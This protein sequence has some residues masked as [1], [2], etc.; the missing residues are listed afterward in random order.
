MSSWTTAER[1]KAAP[2]KPVYMM[3]AGF[4]EGS[5]T[6]WMGHDVLNDITLMATERGAKRAYVMSG[7]GPNEMQLVECYD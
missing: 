4:F 5:S 7:Y 6:S 2:K 3:G 1:A